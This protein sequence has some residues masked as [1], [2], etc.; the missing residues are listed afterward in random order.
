[1]DLLT[2]HTAALHLTL[3]D[4]IRWDPQLVGCKGV[5]VMKKKLSM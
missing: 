5:A 4:D 2:L 1:M 3:D